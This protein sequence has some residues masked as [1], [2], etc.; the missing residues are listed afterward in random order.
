[1]DGIPEIITSGY[2]VSGDSVNA[3]LRIWTWYEEV[4]TLK[5]SAEGGVVEPPVLTLGMSLAVG[6]V[7]DDGKN[8][9]VFGVDFSVI[10]WSRAH[11][12]IFAWKDGKLIVKDSK[13]WEDASSV[14]GI[15]INDVDS[16]GKTEIITTGYTSG[17]MLIPTSEL[18]IWSVSKT[19]SSI[20]VDVT[21]S[22]V[23]IGNQVTIRG[24]VMD[25]TGDKGIPNV[26]V[27]IMSSRE[28]LPVFT[29]IGKVKTN[30]N[31]EYT[32]SWTP[33]EAGEY[34]IMVSW[35]GDYE[36]EGA[37]AT[38]TLTVEKASSMIALTLSSYTITIG[39]EISVSGTL[40]PAK[41]ATILI[42]YT[43][44]QGIIPI[45]ETVNSNEAG[46]FSTT[47]TANQTGTWTIK[48]SWNGDE[49]YKATESA[50]STLTVTKIQSAITIT[51]SA[52]TVN[53]NENVTITGTLTL[54]KWQP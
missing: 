15:A 48:A 11:I 12:K 8:E 42:E 53:V 17:L 24:Y 37:T 40:Y 10:L 32:L 13:D 7:D 52:L 22:T 19:E 26:E 36:H 47:F 35:D 1:L 21:P 27:T 31:G 6:D 51:A 33:P 20:T 39:E 38:T 2:Q 44:P 34:T 30:E 29:T 16:D 18:A 49:T 46:F 23:V 41:T 3:Q 5:F 9:I 28:P 14:Q 45:T 4:L 54:D 43:N 50:P 25:E